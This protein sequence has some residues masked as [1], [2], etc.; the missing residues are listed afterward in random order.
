MASFAD[1]LHTLRP[2]RLHMLVT[3]AF[4][5]PFLAG[6]SVSLFVLVLQQI[7]KFQ[8]D[9]FGKG[10]SAGVIAQLFGY[11]SLSLMVFALTLGVLF[12]SLMCMGNL[13]ES[14]ELAALKS[15][16]IHPMRVLYPLV[17][18]GVL[19]TAFALWFS[20]YVQPWANLKMWSL[21]YDAKQAKP[22]FALKPGLFNNLI[23][24]YSM[25]ITS[26][27]KNGM[28]KDVLIYDHTANPGNSKVV[29]ADSGR[30]WI[31]N[32]NLYLRLK[33]YH[34]TQYEDFV[35]EPAK[36]N[37]HP[38]ARV[39]FDT[40]NYKM[41]MSGFGMKRTDE[42]LFSGH[43]YVLNVDQLAAKVDSLRRRP[44]ETYRQTGAFIDQYLKLN[45]RL[46]DSTAKKQA[47]AAAKYAAAHPAQTDTAFDLNRAYPIPLATKVTSL[48]AAVNNART[49]KNYTGFNIEQIA[50]Q[51]DDVR[52][53]EIEYQ[54]RFA[55]P[56]A[57]IIFLCIGAPL[58]SII[59][60]GGLG[61]P[62]VV[63]VL[64]FIFFY[65]LMTQGR[66]L[67]REE[68]VPVWFGVWL[69]VIIMVPM[70]VYL[71]YQSSRDSR[72]FD[73]SVWSGLWE[74]LLK[75]FVRKPKEARAVT[76]SS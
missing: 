21:I 66:K 52:K 40:L 28:L 74:K 75:I 48:H 68:V 36:P 63:S 11:T 49:I 7:A 53:Y 9:I 33:L 35:P 65:V 69:P 54:F 45:R 32:E 6:V 30:M 13:G 34:G 71:I 31:D 51:Y 25:R 46:T 15:A 24:G 60:K 3:K 70:A 17:I 14:Y 61:M 41:D 23:D 39:D 16:G 44:L 47:A 38:F 58:G 62:V 4:L 26:R 42:K 64:F 50:A 22:S 59:R 19:L 29:M 5:G 12:S 55:L 72:L 27:E 76:A 73:A 37:N 43:Q 56:L 67:A 20:F 1:L 10:F 57:V 18:M 2:K 8:D